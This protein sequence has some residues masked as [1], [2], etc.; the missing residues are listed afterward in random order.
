MSISQLSICYFYFAQDSSQMSMKNKET[1]KQESK[2]TDKTTSNISMLLSQNVE[3][4]ILKAN[5][6][7]L[8]RTSDEE[9]VL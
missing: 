8:N 4:N 3:L 2:Q 5:E 1:S 7:M 9:P 6:A